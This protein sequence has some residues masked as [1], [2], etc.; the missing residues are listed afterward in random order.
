[1]TI[2]I[3]IY[4][5]DYKTGYYRTH[6]YPIYTRKLQG[7]RFVNQKAKAIKKLYRVTKRCKEIKSIQSVFDDKGN[8]I[9]RITI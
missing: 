7:S 3:F 1:M 2:K 5:H 9:K 6:Y 8:Y 4:D